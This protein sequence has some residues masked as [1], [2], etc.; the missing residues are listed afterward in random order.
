MPF[1]ISRALKEFEGWLR[2]ERNL[3]PRT[4]TAYLYDLD[5][6]TRF[7]A[8]EGTMLD[9]LNISSDELRRYVVH[10]REEQ[11]IAAR[12]LARTLSSIRVFFDWLIEQGRI[13]INPAE[14]LHTPRLPPKLPVY[15]VAHELKRLFA[16]PDV[17]TPAGVRDRAILM[18]FTLAGIRLQELVGL[19]VGDVDFASQTI[20]VFGKG[21]KERLLPLN[22]LLGEA[23]LAWLAARE[24]AEGEKAFF[25]NR[26]GRRL[27]GRMV[28]K[29]VD[30]YALAAGIGRD[31][32][33]PHKLRHSFAT[34]LH[35]RDVD[36]VEIQ[37]LLGHASIATTQIYTHTNPGRLQAA[38]EKL[39]I[40]AP[41]TKE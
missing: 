13:E 18:T 27:S 10:L 32:I 5:R 29:L 11:G 2:V 12:T 36:L 7:L 35:N 37:A 19:N 38:V 24:A 34:M 8:P 6:M 33:S 39:A 41:S 23:H 30:K 14:S 28:E 17:S 16:A 31:G 3:S 21:S 25:V 20:R 22:P 15:L 26:F 40:L 4:R 9:A 1:P